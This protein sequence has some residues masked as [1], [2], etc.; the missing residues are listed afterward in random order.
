MY[1]TREKMMTHFR[2]K[3]QTIIIIFVEVLFCK[4]TYVRSEGEIQSMFFFSCELN[5]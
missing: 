4:S 1:S 2:K 5:Y 3:A